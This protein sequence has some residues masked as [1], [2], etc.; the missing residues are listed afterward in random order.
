MVRWTRAQV[1]FVEASV[2]VGVHLVWTPWAS[3]VRVKL[4]WWVHSIDLKR[5]VVFCKLWCQSRQL[6]VRFFNLS[7]AGLWIEF[8]HNLI[9]A[10]ETSFVKDFDLLMAIWAQRYPWSSRGAS[11]G[12]Q[13]TLLLL[14]LGPEA[15]I[16]GFIVELLHQ[17]PW[18]LA[19]GRAQSWCHETIWLLA[20]GS[21][22]LLLHSEF[23]DV[24][25]LRQTLIVIVVLRVQLPHT[26]STVA[27][28][29]VV[30][31]SRW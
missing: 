27:R 10:T 1:L 14:L 4:L 21:K 22:F 9:T 7:A 3:Y 16:L 2:L 26:W 20:D 29:W 17:I 23:I 8:L 18:T 12:R 25:H 6:F 5:I 15:Q 24:I 19:I 28:W 31:V 13:M 11:R 30:G